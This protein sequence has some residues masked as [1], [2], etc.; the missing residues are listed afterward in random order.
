MKEETATGV[1]K[2]KPISQMTKGELDTELLYTIQTK[3]FAY[4]K[5]LLEAGANPN[6]VDKNKVNDN[7]AI[8]EAARVNSLKIARLLVKHGADV[9]LKHKEGST[10][11]MTAA[12]NGHLAMARYLIRKGADVNVKSFK[13]MAHNGQT[14]LSLAKV[15]PEE[16]HSPVAKGEVWRKKQIVKLLR[17]H[18]A[19]E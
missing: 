14:A 19:K 7:T 2:N 3:D 9:N 13:W 12:L 10:A 18:G 15:K 1:N 11:L 6:A 16:W 5:Q 4:V 17:K 8:D